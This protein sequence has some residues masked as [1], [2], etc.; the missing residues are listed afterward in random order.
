[1]THFWSQ[2]HPMGYLRSAVKCHTSS[3]GLEVE[4]RG[5]G[6]GLRASETPRSDP[7]PQRARRSRRSPPAEQNLR[8][9]GR[10]PRG[11]SELSRGGGRWPAGGGGAFGAVA[12]GR[13]MRGCGAGHEG[14]GRGPGAPPCGRPAQT[15][16]ASA[17]PMT[18]HRERALRPARGM[19]RQG[20]YVKPEV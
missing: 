10:L 15:Q 17:A 8:E 16:V 20:K 9:L 5:A 6:T 11:F 1:M 3:R 2:V 19:N 13:G 18:F 12:S 14:R 7:G 4:P